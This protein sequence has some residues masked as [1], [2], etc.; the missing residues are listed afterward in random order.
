MET[1]FLNGRIRIIN[2]DCMEYMSSLKENEFD[3]IL[4]DVPYGKGNGKVSAFGKKKIKIKKKKNWDL[5]RPDK[6]YFDE[7]QRVSKNQIIFGYNYF[8]D[9]I[10]IT[11]ALI[12][13]DKIGHY[14]FTNPFSDF[15]LA[16]T[17]T[18]KQAKK[19]TV[20]QQGFISEERDYFHPVQKPVK[21]FG[22][23]IND[24][25]NDITSI[26]DPF[27]GSCVTAIACILTNKTCVCCEKDKKMFDLSVNRIKTFLEQ[28]DLFLN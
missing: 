14:N 17:S 3:F 27:A 26:L 21:L 12:S 6:K 2:C 11:N 20:I 19:Y 7:M 18:N 15:E 1:S 23:I 22:K 24:Y 16:W 13:W 8:A 4:T 28:K 9:I 5:T 25:C 10:P